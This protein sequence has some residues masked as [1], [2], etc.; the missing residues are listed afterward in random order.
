M[1]SFA[2]NTNEKITPED[3]S[4]KFYAAT[5]LNNVSDKINAL[6]L[7]RMTGEERVYLS[8][9]EIITVIKGKYDWLEHCVW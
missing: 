5:Q 3:I 6:V 8:S 7:D 1:G 2:F 4:C 9:N